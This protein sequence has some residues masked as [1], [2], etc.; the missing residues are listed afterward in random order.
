MP[1]AAASTTKPA[2]ANLAQQVRDTLVLNESVIVECV[3]E[4]LSSMP[5]HTA[6]V[7]RR[8]L[9]A[10]PGFAASIKR[11]TVDIGVVLSLAKSFD[12]DDAFSDSAGLVHDIDFAA[13]DGKVGAFAKAMVEVDLK[14]L[15]KAEAGE[16][17]EDALMYDMLP[18]DVQRRRLL[19]LL[20]F[21]D[22]A[23]KRVA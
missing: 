18:A 21:L 4:V 1:T 10:S 12:S 22:A 15:A 20:A 23:T 13:H 16:L 2:N 11:V 6:E 7:F 5:A 19:L 9:K 14:T 8:L 3:N 17:A